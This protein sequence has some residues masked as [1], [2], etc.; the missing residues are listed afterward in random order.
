MKKDQQFKGLRLEN[1]EAL[2]IAIECM[3]LI[4]QARSQRKLTRGI[5][6]RIYEED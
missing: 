4:Y 5:I 2:D 6:S 3:E 1:T